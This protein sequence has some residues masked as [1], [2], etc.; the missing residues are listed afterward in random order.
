[1][2]SQIG[3]QNGSQLPPPNPIT[4]R[5]HRR[6]VWWQVLFPILLFG[7]II[8]AVAVLAAWGT[9]SNAQVAQWGNISAVFL[10]LPVLALLLVGSV[11]LGLIIYGMTRLLKVLPS[12]LRLVQ[13]FIERVGE[14]FRK[15]ADTTAKPVIATNSAWAGVRKIFSRD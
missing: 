1:M 6:Q 15:I 2:N 9:N 8:A 10:I 13:L 7:A 12:Y 3:S 5:N 4:Q 14:F 11:I